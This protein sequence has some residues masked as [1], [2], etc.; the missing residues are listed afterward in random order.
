MSDSISTKSSFSSTQSQFRNQSN[1]PKPIDSLQNDIT[2]QNS[3]DS[4]PFARVNS[5]RQSIVKNENGFWSSGSLNG[6]ES[7]M[8]TI[9]LIN[10]NQTP[11]P[12]GIHVIP[13]FDSICQSACIP[14][15]LSHVNPTLLINPCNYPV[16]LSQRLNQNPKFRFIIPRLK[17]KRQDK[18]TDMGLIIQRIE[19]GGRVHRD[20]RLQVGDRLVEINRK[21]LIGLGFV[22]CQDI[23][24]EAIHQ[25][26][27][28]QNGLLEFK[29]FRP[30]NNFNFEGTKQNHEQKEDH[31]CNKDNNFK[32]NSINL[33]ALNTKK[34][35]TKINVKLVKGSEGLGFKL[36]ARDY[37]NPGE[38]SP[39]Y[40][41]NILP[42]GAALKDGRLQ[43]GDRLLEVNNI[44]MTQ[45]TLH[46]A[47]SILRDTNLGDAV[48]IVVSRQMLDSDTNPE[49]ESSSDKV[50]EQKLGNSLSTKDQNPK[51]QKFT[52]KIRVACDSLGISVKG[53]TKRLEE[54]ENLNNAEAKSAKRDESLSPVKSALKQNK[55][56]N[57]K[58]DEYGDAEQ[59]SRFNR[60]APSRRSVSEKRAKAGDI[61]NGYA[62][63]GKHLRNQ[64]LND[65]NPKRSN[66]LQ[67]I[68][69]QNN[70][71][72]TLGRPAKLSNPSQNEY[73]VPQNVKSASMESI[74]ICQYSKRLFE[75]KW[76]NNSKIEALNSGR[77]DLTSSQVG[78]IDSENSNMNR[79]NPKNRSFLTAIDKSRE[80]LVKKL[81]CFSALKREKTD[82]ELEERNLMIC[83]KYLKKKS[84]TTPNEVKKPRV[85]DSGEGCFKALGNVLRDSS[86]G[87]LFRTRLG[88][89][90]SSQSQVKSRSLDE[91]TNSDG[92]FIHDA[93][94]DVNSNKLN[95]SQAANL[96]G[97]PR[98]I[99]VNHLIGRYK[100]TNVGRPTVYS[101]QEEEVISH[102][103]QKMADWRYAI[104]KDGL[105]EIVKN[106]AESLGKSDRFNNGQPNIPKFSS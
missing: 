23:L 19:P 12:L 16:S 61:T 56:A 95:R 88:Q 13:T 90:S 15:H 34:M 25:S 49:S 8:Y 57:R 24:R 14:Y 35:G 44:D 42:V 22:K 1:E 4:K 72:Q 86:N 18:F 66:T 17:P 87:F 39:I 101:T 40:I 89:K 83:V 103:L 30:A 97:I 27:L 71:C 9:T 102:M 85:S 26:S 58:S 74:P 5:N 92:Y 36:S 93:I 32:S 53:K 98:H 6:N 52:F 73:L 29:I 33:G 60:D 45:K 20:G 28:T 91:Q 43:R 48:D 67:I 37:C 2:A 99:L 81:D 105:K 50:A 64:S 80:K 59:F 55:H 46:E 65:H 100:S 94:S 82:Y 41:K 75:S 51:R 68:Q 77:N 38:F 10:T 96:Y 21:N 7:N 31:S 104:N 84:T 11:G 106:Y 79:L 70:S 47:V 3:I 62:T 78:D 54:S 76:L 63:F 69:S